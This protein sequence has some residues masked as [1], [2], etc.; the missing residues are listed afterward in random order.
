MTRKTTINLVIILFVVA[1]VVWINLPSSS[2]HIGNFVR[3][4]D[5]KLGLDLRGGMQ[6]VLEVDLPADVRSHHPI[7]G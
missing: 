6:V 2:I 1:A 3:D 4:L 7:H 5:T